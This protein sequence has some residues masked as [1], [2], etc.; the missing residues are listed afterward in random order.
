[1]SFG[2]SPQNKTHQKT[3]FRVTYFLQIRVGWILHI[4]NRFKRRFAK[5]YFLDFECL[6]SSGAN[7]IR[8]FRSPK[9]KSSEKWFY[10]QNP[11]QRKFEAEV[12]DE[13]GWESGKNQAAVKWRSC[14]KV[15]LDLEHGKAAAWVLKV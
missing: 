15:S 8:A 12:F 6:I 11:A 10:P 3:P 14:N 9:L 1:M 13:S 5:I 4:S 7:E 2:K